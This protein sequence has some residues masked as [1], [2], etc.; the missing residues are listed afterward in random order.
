MYNGY[1]RLLKYVKLSSYNV[2]SPIGTIVTECPEI[3]QIINIGV[4]I[5]GKL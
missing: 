4:T 2:H 5:Y 1:C 3:S